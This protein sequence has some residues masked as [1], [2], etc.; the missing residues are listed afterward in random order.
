MN[1]TTA[2]DRSTLPPTLRPRDLRG[3]WALF[4]GQR[5]DALYGRGTARY[6]P[7]LE[8]SQW[9]SREAVVRYQEER[10][11]V[12]LFH[13]WDRVPFYRSRFE[14]A[15]IRRSDLESG[16]AS[17]S[18]LPPLTKAELREGGSGLIAEG[19]GRM[20][21]SSTSGSS[22]QPVTIHQDLHAAAWTRAI[23]RRAFRWYGVEPYER[24]V[25]IVSAP[26]AGPR[27]WRHRLIDLAT[28]RRLFE[29]HRLDPERLEGL[30]RFITRYRPA[31][32][33]AYPSVL[34][35]LCLHCEATGRSLADAGV[36]LI[37]S[38][39]EMLLELHRESFRRTFGPLPVL[40]EYGCVEI[41]AMAYTC[42]E[43]RRHVSHENVLL[44]V[45]DDTGRPAPEG[46]AGRILLT[47]LE[48]RGMPLLRLDVGDLG[49]PLTASCRC[50]R[51][52]GTSLLERLEGR[53][54]E[55]IE[56]RGGRRVNAG[57]LHF[58][59][60][61]ATGGR[62]LE[63]YLAVQ[64]TVGEVEVRIVPGTGY[65]A[66][67]AQSIEEVGREALGPG[68]EV[69]CRILESITPPPGKKR[70]YFVSLL[71]PTAPE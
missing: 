5:L 63:R 43:G 12:L 11:R 65:E 15:G 50:G 37:H 33:T 26:H 6:L 23:Q 48:S 57:I 49:V 18:A 22:G 29:F 20:I 66:G 68:F 51:N 19:S 47:A 40:D 44:E 28:G 3:R 70:S 38:Q 27:A 52:P 60:K 36:R 56:G 14:A 54:F 10:L 30:A 31:F 45:V 24:R 21:V 17:L 55:R 58:I 69:R 34:H 53:V 7:F 59:V 8:A 25:M 9:W 64:E 13:C 35:E 61:Q 41:G 71:D 4:A 32:I 62:G 1:P 2:A 42:P 46:S 67:L 39:S 16:E